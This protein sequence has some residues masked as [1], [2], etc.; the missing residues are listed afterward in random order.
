MTS[1]NLTTEVIVLSSRQIA[2]LDAFVGVIVSLAGNQV[3]TNEES[4]KDFT[5]IL[6]SNCVKWVGTDSHRVNIELREELKSREHLLEDYFN[7]EAIDAAMFSHLRLVFPNMP[8]EKDVTRIANL[9]ST[10]KSDCRNKF[11]PPYIKY[12]KEQKDGYKSGS[13]CDKECLL[14]ILEKEIKDNIDENFRK[15]MSAAKASLKKEV[16]SGPEDSPQFQEKLKRV[17]DEKSISYNKKK[18]DW[19][20]ATIP[21][22]FLAFILCSIPGKDL[23]SLSVGSKSSLAQTTQLQAPKGMHGQRAL[24]EAKKTLN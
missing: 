13:Y 22:S 1:N 2:F 12:R 14:K 9:F 5:T 8:T 4:S 21:K 24:R 19:K 7:I 23:P 20:L 3:T 15:A 10:I 18:A 11:S 6:Y 17:E 16:N